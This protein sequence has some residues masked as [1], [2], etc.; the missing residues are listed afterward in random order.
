MVAH[1][2]YQRQSLKPGR[3]FVRCVLACACLAAAVRGYQPQVPRRRFL[4]SA[5]IAI[6]GGARAATAVDDK[7][8]GIS[9]E[10]IA[11]MVK[12]DLVENQFLTNGRLTRSIYS[13]DAKFTDEIDTYKLD[14]WMKGTQKLFVGDESHVELVGPVVATKDA[15][16]FRFDEVLAFNIPLHP[17]VKLTG[18]VL[19]K[20]QADGLI[21][22]YQ[23]FWDQSVKDVL[24]SAKI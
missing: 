4:S 13:E 2:T 12:R 23:E 3:M 17:K 24:L 5:A 22:S 14:Q 18:K 1:L 11:E 19:L 9:D 10:K 6:A 7:L 15:V 8:V 21:S 16:E 20:R